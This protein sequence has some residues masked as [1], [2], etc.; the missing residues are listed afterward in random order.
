MRYQVPDRYCFFLLAFI[1]SLALGFSLLGIMFGYHWD[2]NRI[3]ESARETFLMGNPLPGWYVY[4][5]L[6]HDLASLVQ[7]TKLFSFLYPGFEE[8]WKQH[9]MVRG[10]FILYSCAG[11]VFTFLLGRIITSSNI[12][13]LM[14]AAL[15]AF[16]WEFGYH[17]RWIAPDSIMMTNVVACVFYCVKYYSSGRNNYFILA[18]IFGG[19]ATASKYPAGLVALP[20]LMATYFRIKRA[21]PYSTV[22]LLIIKR[23]LTIGAIAALTF[24]MTT[25]GFI[26]YFGQL[27]QDLYEHI[28]IYQGKQENSQIYQLQNPPWDHFMVLTEYFSMAAFSKNA[29]LSFLSSMFIIPGVYRLSKLQFQFIGITFSFALVYFCF[30]CFQNL[31]IARNYQ[32]LLPFIFLLATMGVQQV[33]SCFNVYWLQRSIIGFFCLVI[34]FNAFWGFKAGFSIFYY[35]QPKL[36]ASLKKYIQKNSNEKLYLTKKVKLDYQKA[37]YNLSENIV[38]DTSLAQSNASKVVSYTPPK[39]YNHLW[40]RYSHDF[41]EKVIGQHEVNINYYPTWAS[42]KKILILKKANYL[43]YANNLPSDLN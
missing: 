37:G 23:W 9:L 41:V 13:A 39:K 15:L 6:P 29:V 3:M 28:N 16:S 31:M 1:I 27:W 32:V 26:F 43:K 35:S 30:F 17:I 38:Q 25:P 20:L 2:E 24:L 34:G 10:V 5:S 8:A 42:Y 7:L 36:Y 18:G 40:P 4:P 22:S 12:Y 21:Y 19:L 14:A 11:I 33:L